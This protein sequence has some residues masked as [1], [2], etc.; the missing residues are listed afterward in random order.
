MEFEI[1]K[2]ELGENSSS[3]GYTVEYQLLNGFFNRQSEAQSKIMRLNTCKHRGHPAS[4]FLIKTDMLPII[5]KMNLGQIQAHDGICALSQEKHQIRVIFLLEDSQY[6]L[7][8]RK[9]TGD[10]PDQWWSWEKTKL[11]M[12]FQVGSNSRNWPSRRQ[13][14]LSRSHKQRGDRSVWS[15]VT[16]QTWSFYR[17]LLLLLSFLKHKIA[18]SQVYQK[19][20]ERAKRLISPVFGTEKL[21]ISLPPQKN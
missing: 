13:K 10:F 19:T 3:V 9:P 8:H 2:A 11:S 16:A 4:T 6:Y 5:G 20:Q 18:P 12:C 1:E 17:T 15:H 21:S 14:R 7:Q